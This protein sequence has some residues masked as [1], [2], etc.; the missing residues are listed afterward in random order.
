MQNTSDGLQSGAL[1]AP[2]YNLDGN[3]GGLYNQN[4]TPFVGGVAG[5]GSGSN[6]TNYNP[7][8]PIWSNSGTFNTSF[9]VI[10][11]KLDRANHGSHILAG[12]ASI[13]PFQYTTSGSGGGAELNIALLMYD[14]AGFNNYEVGF[15]SQAPATTTNSMFGYQQ[16]PLGT[17]TQKGTLITTPLD[18]IVFLMMILIITQHIL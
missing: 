2:A 9:T 18:S 6:P 1:V 11:H 7:R 5:Q 13:Y 17:Q 4:T 3:Q 10:D 15:D 14:D 8:Y 16:T 12:G